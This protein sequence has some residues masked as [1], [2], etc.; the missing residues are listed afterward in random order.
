[1]VGIKDF[2]VLQTFINIVFM[3]MGLVMMIFAKPLVRYVN[4]FQKKHQ[5]RSIGKIERYISD[6]K[7]SLHKDTEARIISGAVRFQYF[8]TI[9]GGAFFFLI[10]LLL[11]LGIIQP[12]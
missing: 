6:R 12:R 3:I 9:L 7:G 4:E 8:F 2:S 5:L 10:G 1:V 11:L